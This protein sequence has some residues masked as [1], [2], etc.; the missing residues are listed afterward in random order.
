MHQLVPT[1]ADVD[2]VRTYVAGHRPRPEG[3][4]WIVVGMI[5][6]LDGASAL[7]GRSG[8]LGGPADKAVFRA[9]RAVADVIL[10]GAGTVRAERYG[11][12]RLPPHA[13][14][15]RV[16]AGRSAEPPRLAVVTAS[17]DLDLDGPLLTSGV[18]PIVFTTEDA[19]PGRVR[20]LSEVADVRTVGR[21]RVDVARAVA[22]LTQDGVEV[23]VCEGGPILNGALADLGMIDELCLSVSPMLAGGESARILRGAITSDPARY[24]LVSLLTED[25][26]LFGRW[27]RTGE[28]LSRSRTVA[29]GG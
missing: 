20:A 1:V 10:V 7:D 27:V 2:P 16:E 11:P 25:G 6:S 14:S 4:P 12:V 29:G 21:G 26:L 8:G 24:E 17:C 22:E 15:I 13:V 18:R 3:R 5:T 23:V 28:G 19:D 9:V